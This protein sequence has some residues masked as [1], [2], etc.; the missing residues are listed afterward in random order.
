MSTRRTPRGT[1]LLRIRHGTPV[2]HALGM[3]L[4]ALITLT[5]TAYIFAATLRLEA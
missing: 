3:A 1:Y 4:L 5:T 2:A